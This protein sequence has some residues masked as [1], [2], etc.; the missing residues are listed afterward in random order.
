M[1]DRKK[2][3]IVSVKKSFYCL[4]LATAREVVV[5]G[6]I[7]PLPNSDRRCRGVINLRGEIISV[8][9]LAE[10]MGKGSSTLRPGQSCIV[11]AQKNEVTIGLL[12]DAVIAVKNVT[13]PENFIA[14]VLW[15]HDLA[16]EML[17]LDVAQIIAA[18]ITKKEGVK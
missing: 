12:I 5:A 4:P 9:D 15:D 3:L 16:A 13:F 17:L 8:V 7:T 1:E 6:E 18:A 14:G 2:Y 10:A 11:I